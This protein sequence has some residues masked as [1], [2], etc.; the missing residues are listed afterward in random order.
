M[1]RLPPSPSHP[2]P[3]L[4]LPSIIPAG[5]TVFTRTGQPAV[6]KRPHPYLRSNYI[7]LSVK[8]KKISKTFSLSC[9]LEINFA[10]C[11]CLPD[12]LCIDQCLV[13]IQDNQ[14]L[15][16]S[17][18]ILLKR[19]FGCVLRSCLYFHCFFYINRASKGQNQPEGTIAI[20]GHQSHVVMSVRMTM[21]EPQFHS[22]CQ[23]AHILTDLQRR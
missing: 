19:K 7:L 21:D 9:V 11:I 3:S 22:P 10:W 5:I 6:A 17:A 18:A 1:F 23:M 16:I 2:S 4:R 12:E 13:S 8:K 14:R 20:I 15:N